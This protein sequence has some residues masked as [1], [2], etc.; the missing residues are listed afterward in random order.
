MGKD[1]NFSGCKLDKEI[2]LQ[3]LAL[4]NKQKSKTETDKKNHFTDST[5]ALNNHKK[6]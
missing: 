4:R 3:T 1:N 6:A 5:Y 2:K